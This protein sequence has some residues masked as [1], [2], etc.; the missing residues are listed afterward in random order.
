MPLEKIA[1]PTLMMAALVGCTPVAQNLPSVASA[2]GLSFTQQILSVHNAARA[3]VGVAPLVWNAELAEQAATHAVEMARTGNFVHASADARNGK[4]ENMWFGSRG[5]YSE[6]QMI[7]Y[8]VAE[9]EDFKAGIFPDISTTGDWTDV[10]HYSQIIWPDTTSVGCAV[11][12]NAQN[13]YLVCRYDPS[14][15]VPG[16]P[17]G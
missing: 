3:E 9:K 7:G 16:M 15:N 14:G 11:A 5:R 8:F 10:G 2:S 12:S 1:I 4:G 6:A 13:E 17:V